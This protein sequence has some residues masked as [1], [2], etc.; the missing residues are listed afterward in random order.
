MAVSV[1][2]LGIVVSAELSGVNPVSG[3]FVVPA[4]TDRALIAVLFNGYDA[5]QAVYGCTYGGIPGTPVPDGAINARPGIADRIGVVT[6][7]WNEAQIAAATSTTLESTSA[8][9]ARRTLWAFA[10]EGVDQAVVIR[11]S[12]SWNV[13]SGTPYRVGGALTGLT[14]GDLILDLART[15]EDP[16]TATIWTAATGQTEILGQRVWPS[17]VSWIHGGETVADATSET[18][19]RERSGSWDEGIAYVAIALAVS[20]PA[21][22]QHAYRLNEPA[23]TTQVVDSQ[24]SG[25]HGMGASGGTTGV[26]S[27]GTDATQPYNAAAGG[28]DG[29]AIF[30]NSGPDA[31]FGSARGTVYVEGIE[32]LDNGT[33]P[34][35]VYTYN[36]YRIDPTGGQTLDEV[37]SWPNYQQ[38]MKLGF[39]KPILSANC[40]V[41]AAIFD[42]I[43]RVQ[44]GSTWTYQ[45][46][47]GRQGV[48]SSG[49]PEA[50]WY[51][52]DGGT[53][54]RVP[55]GEWFEIERIWSPNTPGVSDGR[56][57][58]WLTRKINGIRVCTKIIDV[59]NVGVIGAET[60]SDRGR[61][62]TC[63][64]EPIVGYGLA[65]PSD[66]FFTVKSGT[67]RVSLLKP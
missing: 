55:V 27:Y 35:T 25:A 24:Y 7:Y 60:C 6:W 26:V 36:S 31:G 65:L 32:S 45:Y 18:V 30:D 66:Q 41:G 20:G 1:L 4:G 64:C 9:G 17:E 62:E 14:E 46:K 23:G 67:F 3:P 33:S 49:F 47:I 8:T 22:I 37:F 52:G 5:E 10:V 38:G 15:L 57:A 28:S 11:D 59:N 56:F 51:S 53:D 63:S 34:G 12:A 29:V 48:G 43:D 42:A 19:Q 39:I 61:L 40:S 2:N 44:S 58:I 16:P 50:F 13:G 54:V 21:G